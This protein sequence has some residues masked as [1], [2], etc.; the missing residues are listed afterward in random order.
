MRAFLCLIVICLCLS[1]LW[2]EDKTAEFPQRPI[3]VSVESG[4]ENVTATFNTSSANLRLIYDLSETYTD[5]VAMSFR[6]IGKGEACLRV[7]V[8]LGISAVPQKRVADIYLYGD[9]VVRHEEFYFQ[10]HYLTI[11]NSI[12]GHIPLMAMSGEKRLHPMLEI[13]R[14]VL[15]EP[16][17]RTSILLRGKLSQEERDFGLGAAFDINRHLKVRIFTNDPVLSVVFSTELT[18][19]FGR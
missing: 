8:L 13:E 1:P 12:R 17:K 3:T 5:Q 7:P 4:G 16:S 15:Y 14:F 10:A 11:R 2:A 18:G 9:Y 19:L 6:V